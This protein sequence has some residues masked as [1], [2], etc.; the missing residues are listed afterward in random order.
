MKITWIRTSCVLIEAGGSCAITDPWFGRTMRG[1][2]VFARPGVSLDDLPPVDLVL[3]SHLHP[4]HFAH[5]AVARFGEVDVVGPPGAAARL[6]SLRR[7][8]LWDLAPWSERRCGPFVVVATPAEHTG[9]PPAEVNYVIE[10]EGLRVFFGGDARWSGAFDRVRDRLG[11]VDVALVPV[12][13]TLI[14][15]HRTTMD[16]W[17]AAQACRALGADLAIPIHEGGEWLPVPPASWHPGRRRHFARALRRL[18]PGCGPLVLDRGESVELGPVLRARSR[19]GSRGESVELGPV[20]RARSQPG[21][22]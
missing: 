12:G 18:A 8:R 7:A 2:P 22:G 13:G 11:P 16:P 15:G 4:D 17:D 21:S 3:A 14:F 19:P 1:L 5:R 6:T 10:A 9:P 20:L